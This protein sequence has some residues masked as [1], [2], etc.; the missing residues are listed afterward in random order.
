MSN[1][2]HALQY[3]KGNNE[4]FGGII[5]IFSGDFYQ[6]PPVFGSPLY[7]PIKNN[8]KATEQELL[9]RLGRLAWKSV[10]E[11]IILEEQE[12]MKND[13]EYS[14]AVLR[15]RKRQCTADDVKLFNSR[16][17]LSSEHPQG[18]N[19]CTDEN[20][21]AT[22]IVATNLLHQAINMQKAKANCSDDQLILCAALDTI[23]G[24]AILQPSRSDLLNTDV[25]KLGNEGALPGFIPLYNGMPVILRRKNISTEL[26]IAN[27]S[28]GILRSFSTAICPS[29]FTYCT[30][31][32]VEFPSSK[33]A[34][35]KLPPKLFPIEPIKW[36]FTSTIT[37]QGDNNNKQ[38]IK[39][40]IQRSQMPFEPGFALT[41]HS[42]QGKTLL[43]VLAWLHE[44]GFAAYVSALRPK[45]HNGLAIIQPVT[46]S[47]LNK[48]LP[49]DLIQ[50]AK[51]HEIMEHN[52][53]VRYGFQ[54]GKILPVP[55][56]EEEHNKK[57][58]KGKAIF[59]ETSARKNKR[60]STTDDNH[61]PANSLWLFEFPG[62]SLTSNIFLLEYPDKFLGCN[63]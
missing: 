16:V 17:V 23:N 40:R 39:A 32:I 41:G 26:G 30:G 34:L 35:Q 46:L 1:T 49:Y 10:T 21:N 61:P 36:T 38:V 22:A 58:L 14:E 9:K 55:D 4:Y 27:G 51:R 52:T 6:Y 2:D 12:R 60:T 19:M 62:S 45:S 56:P 15:L 53:L 33:V 11:V 43:N 20:R 48:P 44:G 8:A 59:D 18:V 31:A 42:A 24:D 28:Q 37:V 47:D 25:S 50:E 29:G 13:P 5:M 57:F 3:A 63:L 54:K 7:A